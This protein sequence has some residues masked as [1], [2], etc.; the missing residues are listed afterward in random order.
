MDAQTR[1]KIH[2][3]IYIIG[4]LDFLGASIIIPLLIIQVKS[5]GVSPIVTG[6]ISSVYGTLQ[7]VTS[8]VVGRWSDVWGRRPVLLTCLALTA[9]SYVV[10]GISSAL[11]VIILSRIIAG[12]F[13]H[14]QTICRALLADITPSEDQSHVFGVFNAMSS[15]GFIIGPMVGGHISEMENGFSMVCNIGAVCFVLDLVFCWYWLPSITAIQDPSKTNEGENLSKV[16]AFIK[17]IDWNIFW[18]I[19][20]IRFFLSFSSLVYRSNFS[21]LID[22]NFGASPKVIGYLISFQGVISTASS[23]FTGK[24]SQYYADTQLELYH[25]SVVLTL[26][27]LGLTVA[28]SLTLL[29]I[30]LIPLCISSA[31]IRVSS[32]RISMSRCHPSQVGSVSG[33]SQSIASFS[34]M[35]T[36]LIAGITQEISVYGPGIMGTASSVAGAA[37]AGC[38]AHKI[39]KPKLD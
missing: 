36:P 10:L 34:R 14:S 16:F 37:L 15:V 3:I 28:P 27:L 22:Q 38:V 12:C 25:G 9:I 5:L 2:N 30:C 17:D 8:P 33:L 13:K 26:S 39:I 21:L 24:I 18:D 6:A 1:K 4:F 19:F 35:V 32:A 7:L 11:P 20:L 29:L 23:F 31:I